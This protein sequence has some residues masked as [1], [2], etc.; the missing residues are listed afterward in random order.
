MALVTGLLALNGLNFH[1]KFVKESEIKHGRTAMLALPTLVTLDLLKPD[2]LAINE[3]SSTQLEYQ[4][5]LLSI[6]GCS[7]VSQM[8]KSYNFPT[9]TSDWFSMK[10]SHIPG[11]YYFDPL[12]ISTS[13]NKES[14]KNTEMLSG[15]IAMLTT[16]GYMC[17]ELLTGSS[18]F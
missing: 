7:E 16:A 13:E 18:P 9:S 14:L 12:N 6:F 10:D 1:S 4:L 8:L 2:T 17:N 5:L 3:L 15:R 11:D